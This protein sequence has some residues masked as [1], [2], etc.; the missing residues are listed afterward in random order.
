LIVGAGLVAKIAGANSF[1]VSNEID[2]NTSNLF[3]ITFI[4]I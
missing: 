2:F 4:F 1:A 3:A